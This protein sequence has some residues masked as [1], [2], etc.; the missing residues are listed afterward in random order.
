M[1]LQ[2]RTLLWLLSYFFPSAAE[3]TSLRDEI[4]R[5]KVSLDGLRQ[6][7]P[8]SEVERGGHTIDYAGRSVEFLVGD[9]HA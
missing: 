4:F 7:W 2:D 3:T 1:T 5:G 9:E 6:Q 8:Y